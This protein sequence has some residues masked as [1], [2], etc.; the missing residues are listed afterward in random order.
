MSGR[1]VILYYCLYV[2]ALVVGMKVSLP[3]VSC[4]PTDSTPVEKSEQVQYET[5][6]EAVSAEEP[7]VAI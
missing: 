4:E 5:L 7:T 2:L 1:K 3:L 6:E